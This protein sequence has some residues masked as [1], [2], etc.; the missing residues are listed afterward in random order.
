MYL[1][2]SLPQP[3]LVVPVDVED[4][5]EAR[6]HIGRGSAD[7]DQLTALSYIEGRRTAYHAGAAKC[8]STK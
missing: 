2:I 8:A 1:A 6:D 3:L 7:G 5:F 4:F